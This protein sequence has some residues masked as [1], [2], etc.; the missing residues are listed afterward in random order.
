MDAM[1]KEAH[2]GERV[3]RVRQERGLSQEQLAE[4]CGA[5]QQSIQ[6]LEKGEVHRPRYIM[7]LAKALG[8]NG[9]WLVHGEGPTGNSHY[10][11]AQN[12]P[13]SSP[14]LPPLEQMPRDVPVLG[15]ARGGRKGSFLLNEGEPIDWV[16]RPPGIMKAK[17]IYS[18]Y[19]EGDSM[20]DRFLPG[21][22]VYVH[23]HKKVKIG[24]YV[25]VQQQ[26]RDGQTEAYIK[27]LKRR[28]ASKVFLKQTNP[29]ETLE[30]PEKTIVSM[31]LILTLN[32]LM[33]V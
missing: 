17:D 28:T 5:K 19:V 12:P 16:R 18:I 21:D 22:L 4:L 11:N 2:I 20:A 30:M 8:V 23:P 15:T 10:P 26:T 33:G 13:Q 1:V 14:I 32:D 24:D 7:E 6:A 25:I 27:K 3:R 31:H 9:D 29:P